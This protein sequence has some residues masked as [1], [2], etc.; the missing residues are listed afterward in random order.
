[1]V[2]PAGAGQPIPRAFL[3]VAGSTLAQHQL[4]LTIALDCQRVICIARGT[5]PE[6][7]AVQH[8]AEDA[9]QQFHI[10]TAPA[11]LAA[12]VTAADDLI[13]LSEGLLP[14]PAHAVPLLESGPAV[15]TQPVE[16][17]LAEGFERID[18]NNAA[19]GAARLPGRLVEQLHELPG[20][21]DVPSALTRIALQSGIPMREVPSAARLGVGWKMIRT[22]TEALGVEH[23]WLRARIGVSRP[24]SPG[25]SLA[26]IGVLSFGPS[27]LHAG[28][29]STALA[30]GA[31]LVLAIAAGAAWFDLVAV[32][33]LAC[34][35]AWLLAQA[36]GML[37]AAERHAEAI[38]PPAIP[39]AD[40]LGWAVDAAFM[41]LAIWGTQR[42][43]G[44]LAASTAFAPVMLLLLLH[45]VA[46]LFEER[47]AALVADRALLALVL[48]AGATIGYL[49]PLIQILCVGLALAGIVLP[50][51]R[52]G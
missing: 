51:R 29:A 16:G 25:R 48:C 47:L 26:R 33:F 15:L 34:A 20:D 24:G 32:G 14:D 46:R 19:A 38:A 1:M 2:E 28:N 7:L 40:A 18:I 42:G 36:A 23:E 6:L 30:A 52:H 3:R 49:A 44:D 17:A 11:Q 31:L 35:I 37:R 41:L 10:V 39:R 4:G 9:G 43:P 12:L 22:E 8:R 5:S 45:L 13:V 50:A 27:L 21:W